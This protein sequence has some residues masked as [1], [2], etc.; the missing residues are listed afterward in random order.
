MHRA[1]I[2]D[3]FI[4]VRTEVDASDQGIPDWMC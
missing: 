4:P 1:D 3:N 2:I